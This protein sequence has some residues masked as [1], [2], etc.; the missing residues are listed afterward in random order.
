M[1]LA[2]PS[3]SQASLILFSC[4]LPRGTGGGPLQERT[5]EFGLEVAN[6]QVAV[7]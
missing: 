6:L 2:S 3:W 7:A 1:R 5:T 4:C